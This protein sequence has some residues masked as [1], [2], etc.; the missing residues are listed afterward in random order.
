[1]KRQLALFEPPIDP[2][3]LVRAVAAGLDIGSV[4]LD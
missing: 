4:L 1:V 2:A 3:L